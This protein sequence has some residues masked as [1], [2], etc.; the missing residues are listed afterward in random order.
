M[1]VERLED[2]GV[3]GNRGEALGGNKVPAVSLT[4]STGSRKS[5][6]RYVYPVADSADWAG[7][8][9]RQGSAIAENGGQRGWASH[10]AYKQPRDKAFSELS[11][12]GPLYTVRS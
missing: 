3:A 11:T 7:A 5:R 2:D 4:G 10:L 1:A 8:G 6:V 9:R 12:F